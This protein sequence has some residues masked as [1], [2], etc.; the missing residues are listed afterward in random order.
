MAG[1]IFRD[2]AQRRLSTMASYI[3]RSM[4]R[5]IGNSWGSTLMGSGAS[6][7]ALATPDFRFFLVGVRGML[8]VISFR[9]KAISHAHFSC[10]N[11]THIST[12]LWKWAWK[13][14]G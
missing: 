2:C 10:Q 9:G 7:E 12:R 8:N 11:E 3:A 6:D 14:P 4:A 1:T 5:E 13:R